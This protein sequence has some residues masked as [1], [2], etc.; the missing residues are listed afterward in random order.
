MMGLIYSVISWLLLAWHSVWDKVLPGVDFLKT[1]WDWILAIIFLVLTVRAV[2]FP[3]FVKQIR[4]QR[5]MQALQPQLKAL[6]EKH[7]GD[8]ETL[9]R[10]MMELYRREKANPLM[11]CLP[12]L[13]QM[14]VFIG[15][16]H[17]LK[18]LGTGTS[19]KTLYGWTVA[20]FDS[21]AAAKL[22]GV[23]IGATFRDGG[24]AAVLCGILGIVMIA[25]T[26]MTSRQMILKT[27]WS[28]DPTQKTM[29]K[30]MLY[31]IPA[32]LIISAVAFPL[33]LIIYW[34][35]T[36][37]FSLGQQMWVLKKYPPPKMGGKAE[38][39]V[40]VD[41]EVAKALAPKV[42]AKPSNNPKRKSVKKNVG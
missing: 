22:F 38:P 31:G 26:Y 30:L 21:G 12:L 9:Q 6:Q 39:K 15:V 10:E 1:N 7:K 28:E 25:T 4:S 19:D 37:L 3:L 24:S 14:P 2:L 27:G 42:G 20:Q 40:P 8:K 34:T 35:T 5:A 17:I 36:N 18:R 13:L 41:P 29:Q 32:T 33:G 23:S 11:G 16:F